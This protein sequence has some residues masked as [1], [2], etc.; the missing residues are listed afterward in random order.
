MH[1]IKSFGQE[2]KAKIN[3][4]SKTQNAQQ[5]PTAITA[6]GERRKPESAR[7][8]FFG[9]GFLGVKVRMVRRTDCGCN[10]QWLLTDLIIALASLPGTPLWP[11]AMASGSLA[12]TVGLFCSALAA[13]TV[14]HF[15]SESD[16]DFCFG[17]C[18]CIWPG[19]HPDAT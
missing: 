10:G 5:H 16:S 17:V 6:E 1:E 14:W 4:E 7:G 15:H 9:F 13:A 18:I 11:E 12:A 2:K 19:P 8:F 3:V